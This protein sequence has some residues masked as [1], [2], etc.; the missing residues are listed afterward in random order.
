M[1]GDWPAHLDRCDLCATRAVDLGRWLDDVREA[2]LDAA[3]RAFPP[4]RLAAQQG[5]ILRR[6]EQADEPPRVIAFP[7]TSGS[8]RESNRRRVAPAWIGVA[9]A[10]GIV[11]G[12]TG[13]QVLSR[14]STPAGTQPATAAA[15]VARPSQTADAPAAV[16]TPSRPEF[17]DFDAP[18]DRVTPPELRPFE[19]G[20]PTLMVLS[21]SGV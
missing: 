2:A 8:Q 10:A 21:G 15:P 11:L 4:E 5:Q 16:T 17:V 19:E 12:A 20:T 3:D 14:I 1:T 6:L 13:S 9:A 18:L 7:A